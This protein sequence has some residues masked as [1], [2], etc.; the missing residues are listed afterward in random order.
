MFAGLLKL[1]KRYL[2]LLHSKTLWQLFL[3]CTHFGM[4]SWSILII[5]TCYFHFWESMRTIFLSL[6]TSKHLKWFIVYYE[7]IWIYSIWVFSFKL[8]L[9]QC[10]HLRRSCITRY[11]LVF[12]MNLIWVLVDILYLDLFK[13]SF[14]L[15]SIKSCI[16]QVCIRPHNKRLTDTLCFS[17]WFWKHRLLNLHTCH[18]LQL[19][20]TINKKCTWRLDCFMLWVLNWRFIRT[21]VTRIFRWNINCT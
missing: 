20:L 12:K 15:F 16:E 5:S 1:F 13:L 14:K 4:L 7:S 6:L 8:W 3:S 2:W 10:W 11:W 17:S 21:D 19:P 18:F 9:C